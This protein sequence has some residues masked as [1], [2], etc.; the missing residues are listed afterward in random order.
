MGRIVGERC[1]LASVNCVRTN[2]QW[3]VRQTSCE[4]RT[5]IESYEFQEGAASNPSFETDSSSAGI[6]VSVHAF[7]FSGRAADVEFQPGL[8]VHKSGS[9][10]SFPAELQ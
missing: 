6:S 7:R 5:G 4:D 3:R 9:C 10:R 8:E 1:S 2:V